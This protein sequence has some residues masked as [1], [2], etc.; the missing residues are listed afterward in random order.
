MENKKL[1]QKIEDL[2]RAS[3]LLLQEK[4]DE[5]ITKLP[6]LTDEQG[7]KMLAALQRE[8]EFLKKALEKTLK[9]K[10]ETEGEEG[11]K[12]FKQVLRKAKREVVKE[13]EKV[14]VEEEADELVDLEEQLNNL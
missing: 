9:N 10:L 12:D 11:I 7:E 6:D 4:K 13:E 2:I 3:N 1:K 8:P 14:S 5:L